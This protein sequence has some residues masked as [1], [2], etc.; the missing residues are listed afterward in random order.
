M[1]APIYES[2]TRLQIGSYAVR[3]WRSEATLEHAVATLNLDLRLW[4]SE[5]V[6]AL[7]QSDKQPAV[8]ELVSQVQSFPRVSAVEVLDENLNGVVA[9]AEWP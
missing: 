5:I 4:A 3:V 7:V 9:Y 2:M 1:S 8:T 6:S